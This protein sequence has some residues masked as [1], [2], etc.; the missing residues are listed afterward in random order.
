MPMFWVEIVDADGKVLMTSGY[1]TDKK[2]AEAKQTELQKHP[3]LQS[4]PGARVRIKSEM[5]PGYCCNQG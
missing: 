5:E 2:H 1:Y 4:H 3:I